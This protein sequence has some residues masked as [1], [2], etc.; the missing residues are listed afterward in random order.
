MEQLDSLPGRV[1]QK[2][3][4]RDPGSIPGLIA[5][6][7]Y[8]GLVYEPLKPILIKNNKE[9]TKE[10]K[11]IESTDNGLYTLLCAVRDSL[12]EDVKHLYSTTLKG[13]TGALEGGME[14][15]SFARGKSAGL[16]IA[17][18]RIEKILKEHCT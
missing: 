2:C 5:N 12:N 4:P 8:N 6:S 7:A 1:R 9:M 10:Q 18:D 16:L 15:K 3:F 13:D 14:I 17:R 11:Q